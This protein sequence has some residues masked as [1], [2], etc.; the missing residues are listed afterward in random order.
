MH[1]CCQGR[2]PEG[3]IER[4]EFLRTLGAGALALPFVPRPWIAGPFGLRGEEELA[5]DHYVPT[6]KKLSDEWVRALFERGVPRVYRG[7]E[8]AAV[9]MPVGGIG[10]GQIYLGSDGTLR[11]WEIMN[12]HSFT[13]YGGGSYEFRIPERVV[14]HGFAIAVH[15]ADGKT[16]L[17]RLREEDVP[18][19]EFRGPYP[20]GE[21]TYPAGDFPVRAHLQVF[22]PFIPLNAAD[23]TLPAT[24]FALTLENVAKRPLRLSLLTWLENVAAIDSGDLF[25]AR[26]VNKVVT[27]A[28]GTWLE[29]TILPRA[30]DPALRPPELFASFEGKDY[31]NW[32]VEGSAFGSHPSPGTHP[33]QNRVSGFAGEGLVNTYLPDD[34]T[35]GRLISPA[36]TVTRDFINFLVGG[37][38][39]A[40]ET[41]IQL[42]IDGKVVAE[43]T[44]K[45]DERLEWAHFEV[46][47]H[48]GAEAHLAIIDRATGP[49]GHINVDEIE[50]A[51]TPKEGPGGTL[52]KQG[53]FGELGM[54]FFESATEAIPVW[55][56]DVSLAALLAAGAHL[57]ATSPQ[58]SRDNRPRGLARHFLELAPGKSRTLTAAL[59]WF[60][61]NHEHGHAY[62]ARFAGARDIAMYLQAY[63]QRL[64]SDTLLYRDTYLDSTLPYWLLERLHAP[65]ANLATNTVQYWENGRFWAW[66][67]VGCCPGTCTHVW[68]YEQALARLFPEL[69][70][71]TREMQDLGAAFHEDGLVGFR[72]N[73]AY[74]ADG[75]AGTVLKLY[76]EHLMSRD[77]SFLEKNWPKIR[78]VMEYSIRRDLNDDGLIEDSQHNTY[79]IEFYGA[80]TFVGS[81]YLAALRAAEEMARRAF[82]LEFAER[83]RRVFESGSRLTVERLFNGEY[84]IQ[85]VDHEKHPRYQYGKGCLA[86]QLFGQ[87]WAHQLGLGRLYPRDQVLSALDAIWRYNWAP[88]VGPQN[89]RHV[90]QRYFARRGEAG[91]L[92]CTWPHSRHP[93]NS[94]VL[95]R[96]EIWTGIEYQVAA[97]MIWEGKLLEGL[98][99][100]R[101]IEERYDGRV[102][103]P[104]NEVE[105]GDHYARALAS[106]GC[107][108]ALA[109]FEYDG[110]AG[111]LG[112][113]PRFPGQH[114]RALFTAAEGWGSL[115]QMKD[116]GCQT[117]EIL[118]RWGRLRLQELRFRVPEGWSGVRARV[119]VGDREIP[120]TA[121]LSG[122]KLSLDL[123]EP[124]AIEADQSLR[125][126]VDRAG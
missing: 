5:P 118:V 98:A 122:T 27:G 111:L 3:P 80:N 104:F 61:P 90:P 77:S 102:M 11:T 63:R 91:L 101:G 76:R 110:P 124:C 4:R 56:R 30:E 81:L 20:V 17:R 105:C 59:V 116:A 79:D 12:R 71:S 74:A 108:I 2:S 78:K 40:R 28:F 66:E 51:D 103:N 36:F 75:Q 34:S 57:P 48:R 60:F 9:A 49:W 83:C 126:V 7:E 92:L 14:D 70:R 68:N 62:A 52:E 8:R 29:C 43:A 10:A 44:G 18:D 72:S 37:G 38:A 123:A 85:D 23:S 97:H 96:D 120:A 21:V 64:M 88:D 6:D 25:K 84:F 115:D 16:L 119:F 73:D 46:A 99:I 89:A 100:V 32:R 41:C 58:D 121:R 106:W 22:S 33:Q 94:G 1:D 53:D 69:A 19:V 93:G 31:G 42:V 47:S 50:F 15:E 35:T 109:G 95:Y 82:D 54:I 125:A 67:G 26:R 87:A 86:D 112:F 13:G 107:F 55:P 65:V 45:N 117:N 24:F 114:F 39:H 113:A